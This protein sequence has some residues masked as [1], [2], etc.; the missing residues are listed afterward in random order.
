MFENRRWHDGLKV[1]LLA[2]LV[3]MVT[4]GCDGALLDV[5]DPDNVV[6]QEEFTA[7]SVPARFAGAINDFR[8][9]LDDYVLY[10]GLHTDEFLLAGT[11]PTRIEVDER[12]PISNNTSIDADVWTPLS[13]ARAT[14]DAMDN[15]FTGALGQEGF[16]ESTA[17]LE[18]GISYARLMGGYT[19][20]MFAEFFCQSIFG[21][22]ADLPQ[23]VD[24]E[25]ESAPLNSVQR[26]QEAVS[27]LES[28]ETFASGAGLADIATAARIGQ[29]RAHMYLGS[30]TGDGTH[31]DAAAAA[32]DGIDPGFAFTFDYSDN[33]PGEENEVFQ[34]TWGV[35]A[36]IR[37]TVGD[38]TDNTRGNEVFAYLGQP[39]VEDDPETA[40]DES[41][42]ATG[43]MAQ[44]LLVPPDVSAAA[45]LESFNGNS[46]VVAQTLYGGRA[47]NTG[48]N[49]PIVLASGWE[50]EMIR[51]EVLLRNGSPGA[52]EDIVNDLLTDPDQAA[53]PMLAVTPDLN[54]PAAGGS[55]TAEEL[56]AF[57]EVTFG[58]EPL[59]G[60]LVELA[61]ARES[62][63][64]LTGDRQ[65]TLRR[66]AVEFNDRLALGLWPDRSGVN[67]IS[68]P[69]PSDEVDNNTNISSA[70]PSGLP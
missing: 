8:E 50:A 7:Q 51:A 25:P 15:D 48:R 40:E 41:Q 59:E 23:F 67:S 66:F 36:N 9:A 26:M 60:D 47:G 42:A 18:Q 54:G 3:A 49:A 5:D 14:S 11:F 68:L 6:P 20:I 13:I 30:A 17:S 56:G 46:P 33:T 64:W 45:G 19:R 69:V 55:L 12:R 65:A 24:E 57:P 58:D 35:N 4:A 38:G 43:W 31:F 1:L 16:E 29:A 10:T 53:N 22:Q 62:G 27:L 37:W 2:G 39:A 61:R 21:G 28:A 34:S 63:L 32:V 70:C 44:G 52:A